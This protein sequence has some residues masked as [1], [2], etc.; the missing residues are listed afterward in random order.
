MIDGATLHGLT[1]LLQVLLIDLALAGDNAVVIGLA[2]HGLPARQQRRA[3]LLGMLGAALLRVGLSLFTLQL[4]EIV[5]LALAGG[6][7]LLW[8]AWKMLRELRRSTAAAGAAIGSKSLAQA[9]LQI[10][11]A[12]LSMSFDNV[13]AVAGAARGHAWVLVAGLT[14]SV[15][16]TGFA[17]HW[18][19][20]VLERQRWIAWLGLSI[21]LYVALHMIWDGAGALLHRS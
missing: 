15:L 13:L 20:R 18:I 4:L 12:D 16:L 7:L 21:V 19:A 14:L 5:G 10:M 8:V 2:V 1:A 11:L 6:L 9:M 3:I 17:A